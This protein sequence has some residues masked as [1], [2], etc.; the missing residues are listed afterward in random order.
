MLFSEAPSVHEPKEFLLA[1]EGGSNLL[2]LAAMCEYND[3][4]AVTTGVV[5]YTRRHRT[6]VK[7]VRCNYNS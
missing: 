6:G 7:L 5:S 1:P 2:G 3:D 4:C